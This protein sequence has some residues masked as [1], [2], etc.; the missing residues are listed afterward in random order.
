MP[1]RAENRHHI[2][3]IRDCTAVRGH[4]DTC[5]GLIRLLAIG[6]A[7]RPRNAFHRSYQLFPVSVNRRAM[8]TPF[9]ADRRAKLTP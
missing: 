4:P 3:S 7:T 1:Q 9:G 2:G 5:E 8:L 6:V